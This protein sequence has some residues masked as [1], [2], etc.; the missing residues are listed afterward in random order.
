LVGRNQCR[1][2]LRNARTVANHNPRAYKAAV[3]GAY[4]LNGTEPPGSLF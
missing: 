4:W 1:T 3:A 2:T